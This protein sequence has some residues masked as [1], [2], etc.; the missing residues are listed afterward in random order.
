MLTQ[1]ICTNLGFKFWV[2]FLQD[3]MHMWF[4]CG[5][6]LFP[7]ILKTKIEMWIFN[8]I[9]II[10]KSQSRRQLRFLCSTKLLKNLIKCSCYIFKEWFQST[11]LP[12]L[13]L[14]SNSRDKL[15]CSVFYIIT[16]T[17]VSADFYQCKQHLG[18]KRPQK[19]GSQAARIPFFGKQNINHGELQDS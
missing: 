17:V 3:H 2:W 13:N 11:S 15:A 7:A 10:W 8:M 12:Q 5:Y 16:V 1:V 4:F 6:R 9:K 19:Q 14:F 18:T